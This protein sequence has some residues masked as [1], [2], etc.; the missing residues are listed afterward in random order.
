MIESL[1]S[2]AA[3][4]AERRLVRILNNAFVRL[5]PF[6]IVGAIALA[7][8]NL[9][10]P[11]FQDYIADG[12]DGRLSDFAQLLTDSTYS[13]ITL[14]ALCSISLSYALEYV[15]AWNGR[16]YLFVPM[17]TSF[18]CFVIL[19]VWQDGSLNFINIGTDGI[20]RAL[21]VS[22][23]S[24]KLL[25][26]LTHLTSRGLA[27]F[28]GFDANLLV[29]SAF[30]AV[31]PVTITLVVSA[32]LRIVIDMLF[33]TTEIT[34]YLLPF[35]EVSESASYPAVV[36]TV[37]TSQLMAFFGAHNFVLFNLLQT[38]NEVSSIPAPFTV[39]GYYLQFAL[40]GGS[41]ATFGLLV[42]MVIAGRD[43]RKSRR[44]ARVAL[45]PMLFNINESLLYGFPVIFNPFYF[46][47][48]IIAPLMSAS[49]SYVAF[50]LGIVPPITNMVAWTIPPILSG[51]ISTGS[52]A[53]SVLQAVCIL[54]SVALY[55]PFVRAHRFHELQQRHH[56]FDLM[57]K[58]LDAAAHDREAI[59]V[60]RDDRVGELAREFSAALKV[61]AKQNK[62]PFF[63]VYQ[64]KTDQAGK[65]VGSEAL[66][67]WHD[68]E[69][70]SIS[71]MAIIELMDESGL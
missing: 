3:R 39:Q 59:V 14:A 20:F 42:A 9:P 8:L 50:S 54:V 2:I 63:L 37:L 57:V 62:L 45:F 22:L 64:P 16:P 35:I 23:S 52:I 26:W 38:I 24:L 32:G 47:P 4:F 41:G 68:T 5:V 13:V 67:R 71:P 10:I 51:Y 60:N 53:A 46:V 29:H 48:F 1:S 18:S 31:L 19:F 61:Q 56:R 11:I 34:Q 28:R 21:I 36:L 27:D 30:S 25:F 17:F 70:G 55:Y 12:L 66:L 44:M 43:W 7:I 33:G 65:L 40:V 15:D 49:I 58:A 69:M 6:V